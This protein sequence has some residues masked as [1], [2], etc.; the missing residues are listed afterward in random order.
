MLRTLFLLVFFATFVST[1]AAEPC[2]R[3]TPECT[4]WVSLGGQAQALIYRTYP[5]DK[6]NEQ[7]TRAL[8]VVH[9]G[10]SFSQ[11]QGIDVV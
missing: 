4:E 7:I 5:V 3:A 6:K 8:V 11:Q 10:R 1:I 9:G 2:T